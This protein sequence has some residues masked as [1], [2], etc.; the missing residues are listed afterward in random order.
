[1]RDAEAAREIKGGEAR[2]PRDAG[3]GLPPGLTDSGVSRSAVSPCCWAP[4]SP[5]TFLQEESRFLSVNMQ[6]GIFLLLCF[7]RYEVAASPARAYA[8]TLRLNASVSHQP[9]FCRPSTIF[10]TP[11]HQDNSPKTDS[12]LPFFKFMNSGNEGGL[13]FAMPPDFSSGSGLDYL[14]D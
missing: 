8:G 9:S 2:P 6:H 3:W 1:M 10:S 12:V 11:N 13:G 7:V 5:E 14:A 4:H